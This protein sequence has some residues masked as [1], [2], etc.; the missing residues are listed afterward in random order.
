VAGSKKKSAQSWP[1]VAFPC[2][3]GKPVVLFETAVVGWHVPGVTAEVVTVA[4]GGGVAVGR[5]VGDEVA[6]GLVAHAV[7]SSIK[8]SRYH[9][10]PDEMR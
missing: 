1:P 4:V 9:L 5:G 7:S 3:S 8:K 2:A 10:R 6:D